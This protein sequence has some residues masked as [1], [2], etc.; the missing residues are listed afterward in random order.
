M[1]ADVE[2]DEKRGLSGDVGYEDI[3]H[4]MVRR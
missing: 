1:M 4:L 2:D 3:T